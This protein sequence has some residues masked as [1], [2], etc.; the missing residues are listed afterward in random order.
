MSIQKEDLLSLAG[1][2]SIGATEAH[3]RSAVSRAYYAAY[4]GCD[5]W[6]SALPSPGSNT[7]IGGGKHQQLINRLGHPAPEVKDGRANIS[8][9][10]AVRLGVLRTQRA[11]A[12][13]ELSGA[14]DAAAAIN[15]CVSAKEIIA[16]L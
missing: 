7:G 4:H 2:L 16:K 11:S 6:H 8:K 10:V 15:A 5:A 9:V 3:W 14:L 12:D 1:E 13:Y